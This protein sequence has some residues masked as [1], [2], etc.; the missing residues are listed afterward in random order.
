MGLGMD[1]EFNSINF[2]IGI[3][4]CLKFLTPKDLRKFF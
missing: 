3:N 2:D 1:E 4:K